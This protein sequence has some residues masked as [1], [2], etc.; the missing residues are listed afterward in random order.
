MIQII[1]FRWLI[2]I[3]LI[4][5]ILVKEGDSSVLSG[6]GSYRKEVYYENG[7]WGITHPDAQL[8]DLKNDIDNEYIRD[9]YVYKV[10][11]NSYQATKMILYHAFVV[12]RTDRYWWS[13]EKDSK[14]VILQRSVHWKNVINHSDDGPRPTPRDELIRSRG[15]QDPDRLDRS[16]TWGLVEFLYYSNL[17]AN[18]YNMY[19]NNCKDF[20]SSV[21]NKFA[22]DNDWYP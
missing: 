6:F 11:L 15:Y 12:F 20:A 9:V 19:N 10:K 13:L 1:G 5:L 2:L 8:L 7:W 3:L 17:V 22:R 18:G 21:Y 16:T 14:R 4:A